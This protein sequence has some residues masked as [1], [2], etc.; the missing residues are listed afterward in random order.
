M[1][2]YFY[3]FSSYSELYSRA[4]AFVNFLAKESE[5][6]ASPLRKLFERDQH[7]VPQ[8]KP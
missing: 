7:P 5:A 3:D 2:K 4:E 1:D 6:I 8:A